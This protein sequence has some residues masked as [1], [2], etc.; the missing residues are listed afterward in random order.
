M[1]TIRVRMDWMDD[2]DYVT[3]LSDGT[4]NGWESV[5]LDASAVDALEAAAVNAGTGGLFEAEQPAL[6]VGTNT[7]GSL[8]LFDVSPDGE[9]SPLPSK[10]IDG[11]RFYSFD[12]WC[13]ER[14]AEP[15]VHYWSPQRAD[16]W[17]ETEQTTTDQCSEAVSRPTERY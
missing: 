9:R 12:G 11:T 7:D 3:G 6:A 17:C 16:V 15:H 8:V 5:W 14:V 10:M 1:D 2:G 4:W 13:F